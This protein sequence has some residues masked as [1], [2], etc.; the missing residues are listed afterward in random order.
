[1]AFFLNSLAPADSQPDMNRLNTVRN[2]ES[3]LQDGSGRLV[4]DS[5]Y[6]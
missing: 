4:G 3:F 2:K 6:L 1:M 5:L